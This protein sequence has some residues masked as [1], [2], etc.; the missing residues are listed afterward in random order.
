MTTETHAHLAF[1]STPNAEHF[2]SSQVIKV[3][4]V[5]V[6]INTEYTTK[7]LSHKVIYLLGFFYIQKLKIN[8]QV[9]F[10]KCKLYFAFSY[11]SKLLKTEIQN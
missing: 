4:K 11:K 3:S 9:N 2:L 5:K 7:S 10:N 8:K 1:I 6:K